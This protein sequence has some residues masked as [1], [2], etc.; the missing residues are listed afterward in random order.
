MVDMRDDMTPLYKKYTRPF[1]Y[2]L[3]MV[4]RGQVLVQTLH[5]SVTSASLMRR[6]VQMPLKDQKKYFIEGHR[7]TVVVDGEPVLARLDELR[8][9]MVYQVIDEE[10]NIRTAKEQKRWLK[11]REQEIVEGPM[12]G[13]EIRDGRIFISRA[14]MLT[15]AQLLELAGVL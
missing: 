3:E 1:I 2:N 9:N 4:G 13:V 5:G 8:G 14:M 7:T 10:G 6:A 11:E 15:K 12:R